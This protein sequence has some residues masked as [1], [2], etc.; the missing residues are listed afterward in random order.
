MGKT[1]ILDLEGET[2]AQIGICEGDKDRGKMEEAGFSEIVGNKLRIGNEDYWI[3][4]K[5]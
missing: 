5:K 1:Y 2:F 4:G 3:M